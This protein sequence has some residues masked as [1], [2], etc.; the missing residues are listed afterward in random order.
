MWRSVGGVNEVGAM[1]PVTAKA[2]SRLKS[3][4]RSESRGAICGPD[5]RDYSRPR[6]FAVRERD[7]RAELAQSDANRLFRDRRAALVHQAKVMLLAS[8]LVSRR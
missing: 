3:I 2:R 1:T 8:D 7:A 4:T 5:R 6:N